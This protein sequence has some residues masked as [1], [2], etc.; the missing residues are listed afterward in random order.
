[1]SSLCHDDNIQS[2][3]FYPRTREN[4]AIRLYDDQ[5]GQIDFL[6]GTEDYTTIYRNT[7]EI[8]TPFCVNGLEHDT[9]SKESAQGFH[10]NYHEATGPHEDGLNNHVS[11]IK[12]VDEDDL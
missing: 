5:D 6:T 12:L 11:H 2:I 10:V 4:I 8:K 9:S 1:Q 7:K 3:L